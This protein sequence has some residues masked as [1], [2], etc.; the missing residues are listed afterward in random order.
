MAKTAMARMDEIERRISKATTETT[1]S[2]TG[3]YLHQYYRG[4]KSGFNDVKPNVPYVNEGS[5][6][7][8]IHKWMPPNSQHFSQE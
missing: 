8:K 3:L 5:K 6:R 1:I 4:G 2:V 7:K